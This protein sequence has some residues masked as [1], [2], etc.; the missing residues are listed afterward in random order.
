MKNIKEYGKERWKALPNLDMSRP[1]V[2]HIF[3]LVVLVLLGI[4]TYYVFRKG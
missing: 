1:N 2:A 3:M 4:A